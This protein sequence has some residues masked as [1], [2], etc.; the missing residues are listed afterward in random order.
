AMVAAGDKVGL[1]NVRLYRPFD[2]DAFV[3]AVPETTTAIAVLDRTKEPGAVGEPL[4][5]DVVAALSEAGPARD[6]SPLVVGGRFGLSSKEFTPAD[7]M[8]VFANLDAAEPRNHFTVGITDDVSGTSLEVK[9]AW[10]EPDD[11]TRAVFVGLGS[12]G[13]VGANKNSVKII[14]ENTD[15]YAQG[16]FVYDSKKA[17]S[18]TVSHLR[19]G[20]RPITSTYLVTQANF[21]ACHQFGLLSVIDVLDLAAPGATFLLNSPYGADTWDHL[22]AK[23]Q[24]AI[25]TKGLKFWVVDAHGIAA[26]AGLAGRVNTVLQTCFFSLTDVLETDAAIS[27]IKDAIAKTYAKRGEVVLERNYAAVDGAVAGLIEIAV[28]EVAPELPTPQPPPDDA[29]ERVVAAIIAGRGDLLPVSAMPVDGT[30]TTGT[31]A[32]EKRSI[33]DE[34]PVW[35]PDICIDCARCALVCPHAAIR[36]KVFDADTIA[37]APEGFKSKPWEKGKDF[38]GKHMTIQ[39]APD[40]CTG[41]KV[42]VSICPAKSKENVSHKSINMEP[43]GDHLD[44]ERQWFDY[45]LEIPELDRTEARPDTLIGSQALQPLF[46]FSGACAGCGET[47]YLKLLTQMFGDRV[48]VANATGCS[49]IYG[50]NLPTTPWA[51]NGDGLGP[52]W[53]NSLFED[54]AEFGLGMRLALDNMR[55]NAFESLGRL[56]PELGAAFTTELMESPQKTEED[57]AK[58]RERVA[59]LR[60]QLAD[61]DRPEARR[62]EGLADTLVATGV[63]IVGGDGWAYDIGFGGLDHTLASGRD[64]N[65]LVLDTEVYSNTGGQASKATPRAAVAKFAAGGKTTAKK[66]LGMIAMAYGNVYVAH[67]ALGAN[68]RQTVKAFAEAE[69]HPGPSLIIAYSPCIAHGIDMETAMTHQKEATD[70]GYW[71]LYRFSPED[72][73]DGGTP[74]KL[75]SRKPTISFKD[76]ALKEARFA[77]LTR[78]NP[79]HAEELL[80]QAQT[81]IDDRWHLYEQTEGIE[82]T[83][84]PDVPFAEE[85]NGEEEA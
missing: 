21:V 12:D 34:I 50:A 58:Q 69:A 17:G 70:S 67:I 63:W 23:T 73:V 38:E 64:V 11:V 76:F 49:S 2:V 30:F 31:A 35:D 45:F 68:M 29:A 85:E 9:E 20:P 80:A 37:D 46:E 74:F 43:K 55:S 52:A 61:I 42:C 77:M 40:D 16:Y 3:A 72:A 71:S 54:N 14:G 60:T 48:V 51:K 24:H 53:S 78:S 13:T 19:F 82:W 26:E 57:I 1:V 75:D 65:V 22:P 44:Q 10:A 59:Q 41:C 7:A 62:L 15:G 5:T 28:P 18:T 81:D 39:V 83:A 79:E 36:M 25:V 47:P 33:A 6:L 8:A 32:L 84:L 56:S 27:F 4:Y 66:D